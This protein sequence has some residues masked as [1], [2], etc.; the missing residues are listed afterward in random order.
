MRVGKLSDLRALVPLSAAGVALGI[1]SAFVVL[2]HPVDPTDPPLPP[3]E[4]GSLDRVAAADRA[5]FARASQEPFPADVRAVG[6]AFVS[7][8]L[9][10]S[11]SVP[12]SAEEREGLSNELRATLGVLR[13][14]LG[15]DRAVYAALGDLR[16]Y[17]AESFVRELRRSA[18]FGE[19]TVPLTSLAGALLGVLERNGWIAASGRPLVP[20]NLLRARFKLHW[21]AVVFGLEDCD[22]APAS[23]CYGQTTL[24]LDPAEL[25]VLMAFM[26]AHPVVRQADF[27][28]A[29]SWEGALDRR[30][31]V[32]LDRLITLDRVLDPMGNTHPLLGEF[33]FLLSRGAMMFRLGQYDA[34]TD[35][36]R[37]HLGK[38]PKDAIARNWYLAAVKRAKGE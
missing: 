38:Q 7:W 21:D 31:L 10:A 24:P 14:R 36:F 8:N 3:V 11:S 12:V 33:P 16:A 4:L 32:L 5:A 22:S 13:A 23:V 17:Q 25:R 29:G 27:E 34:A 18:T 9:A 28:E 26:L 1:T 6:S 19:H 30:R 35:L 20:E 37:L 15:S 2:P